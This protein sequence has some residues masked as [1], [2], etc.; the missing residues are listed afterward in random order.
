MTKN[1]IIPETWGIPDDQA[2]KVREAL[3]KKSIRPEDAAQKAIEELARDVA[4]IEPDPMDWERWVGYLLE[5]LETHSEKG[6]S[7]EQYEHT[8]KVLVEKIQNR[9]KGGKW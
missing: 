2:K 6:K 5:E 8:L 3:R 7:T 9:I 1:P 4:I